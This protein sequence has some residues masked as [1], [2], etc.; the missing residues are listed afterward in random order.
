MAIATQLPLNGNMRRS[1]MGRLLQVVN[2]SW[3]TAT[4]L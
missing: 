1:A 2:L 3:T 4:S